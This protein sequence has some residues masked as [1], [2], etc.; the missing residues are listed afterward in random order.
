MATSLLYV[1]KP[2]DGE[3]LAFEIWEMQS[4]FSFLLLTD[5]LWPGM[6]APDRFLY[7]V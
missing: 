6:E 3:S 1:I 2:S 5:L 7:K 4:T